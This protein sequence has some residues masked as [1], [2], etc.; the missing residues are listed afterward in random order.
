MRTDT[1]SGTT[2]TLYWDE[3]EGSWCAQQSAFVNNS[4]WKR[5]MDEWEQLIGQMEGKHDRNGGKLY[6]SLPSHRSIDEAAERIES[7]CTD[8]GVKYISKIKTT[9]IK[10]RQVVKEPAPDRFKRPDLVEPEQEPEL[11]CI[12][13]EVLDAVS[14]KLAKLYADCIVSNGEE[15]KKEQEWLEV[16]AMASHN[17][18]KLEQ[19]VKFME[20]H[21]PDKDWRAETWE[22]LEPEKV[23]Q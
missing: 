3:E 12:S 4:E 8:W 14:D 23:E 7:F 5:Y 19:L 22:A 17:R 13:K 21:M 16:K 2:L 1:V 18:E 15:V 11:A 10:G 6:F 20:E 9:K